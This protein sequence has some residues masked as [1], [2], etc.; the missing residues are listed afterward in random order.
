MIILRSLIRFWGKLNAPDFPIPRTGQG[1]LSNS[2]FHQISCC[3]RCLIESHSWFCSYPEKQTL[4]LE[5]DRIPIFLHALASNWCSATQIT[6][7]VSNQ[8]RFHM[9]ICTKHGFRYHTHSWTCA[10]FAILHTA[11]YLRCA[12]L[13]SLNGC[14]RLLCGTLGQ[15]LDR[16]VLDS[17]LWQEN[18]ESYKSNLGP[19]YKLALSYAQERAPRSDNIFAAQ[20]WIWQI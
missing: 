20:A 15:A 13:R 5:H 16:L 11:K 3:V 7:A 14:V 12:Q 10:R 1:V 8:I 18:L 9:N 19:V 17:Q 6:A 2:H 4:K